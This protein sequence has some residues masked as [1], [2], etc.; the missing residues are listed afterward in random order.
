[1]KPSASFAAVLT[2]AALFLPLAFNAEALDVGETAPLFE[3]PN[4]KNEIVKLKDY[5]GNPCVLVFYRGLF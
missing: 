4:T 5:R 1:M 2:A 3:L